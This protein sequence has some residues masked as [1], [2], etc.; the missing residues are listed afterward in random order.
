MTIAEAIDLYVAALRPPLAEVVRSTL[1]FFFDSLL[2]ENVA[3]L[4]AAQLR[5][6]RARLGRRGGPRQPLASGAR[7]LHW[8]TARTFIAWCV[9]QRLLNTDPC[10][11]PKA[12][13]LGEL[14][15]RLREDAGILRRDL[16]QQTGLSLA[17]LQRFETSR[18]SLSRQ[19]L[20]RLLL[21]P[22]MSTLPERAKEAGLSLGQGNNGV[23]K[24]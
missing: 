21:H 2:A 5:E 1:H 18:L 12:Q 16:A 13:H 22:S 8:R 11:S 7:D 17:T 3:I 4:T 19:D 23:G 14:V 24:A 15:R 10:A 20:L 6:L 9:E